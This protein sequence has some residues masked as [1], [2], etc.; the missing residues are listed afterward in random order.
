[1]STITMRLWRKMQGQLHRAQREIMAGSKTELVISESPTSTWF[2][3][4]RQVGPEGLKLTGGAPD[5]L[6]G[7]KLGW[8][9]KFPMAYWGRRDHI[10]SR[11][12][13]ECERLAKASG[14]FGNETVESAT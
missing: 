2:Y 9:T 5:A 4:L 7:A 12:C 10:P 3:H 14:L 6:C 8:D 11:F 13:A 1:M